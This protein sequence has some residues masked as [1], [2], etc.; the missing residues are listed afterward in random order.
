MND[1]EK[2]VVGNFDAA[3]AWAHLEYLVMNLGGRHTGSPQE[4][5][6]AQYIAEQLEAAGLEPQIQAVDSWLGLPRAAHLKIEQPFAAEFPCAPDTGHGQAV[7]GEFVFIETREDARRL[8]DMIRGKIVL[9]PYSYSYPITPE[10]VRNHGGI[11]L[12]FG[13]WGPA[14][15][16][17]LRVTAPQTWTYW[18]MPDPEAFR[19][20]EQETIPQAHISRKTYERLKEAGKSATLSGT[21]SSTIDSFWGKSHQ[22]VAHVEPEHPSADGDFM[23]MAAHHDSW[24]PGASDDAAG[25]AVLLEAARNLLKVR[26]RLRR[27]VRFLFVSGH[28]NGAYATTTWYLDNHWRELHEHGTCFSFTDTPGFANAPEFKIE[29]SDE[30]MGFA[31]RCARDIVGGAPKITVTRG[32]KTADRGFY[33][34]GVPSIYTRCAFTKQQTDLW[35]GAF[36][37]Y[38]NHSDH[39]T[40]DKVDKSNLEANAQ[41]RLLEAVRLSSC[42]LLPY[43][44]SQVLAGICGRLEGLSA[45]AAYDLGKTRE[46]AARLKAEVAL[47]PTAPSGIRQSSAHINDGLKKLSRCL[48]WV[49]STYKGRYGQ[50]IFGV[51]IAKPLPLMGTIEELGH[52]TIGSPMDLMLR[53]KLRRDQNKVDDVLAEGIEIAQRVRS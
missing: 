5:L 34:I 19:I 38:W 24:N 17:V 41:I 3:K 23:I 35:G 28:E 33:G 11:G 30:L 42:E 20:G 18:G 40:L 47:L 22:V 10:E 27:A 25:V 46:L 52:H 32:N 12:I 36:L 45:N 48:T 21:F 51:N 4:R 7:S 39:D 31:E 8:R 49:N 53:A 29:V 16:E 37:G 26:G 9:S 50:D 1:F 14:D 2:T 44:F 13:N 6:S 15:L 43:N